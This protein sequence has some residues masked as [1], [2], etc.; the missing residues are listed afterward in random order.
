MR[1]RLYL[2]QVS[3]L[4]A[5]AA[6]LSAQALLQH[7]IAM[8]GGSV[9]G[10]LAGKKL[11]DGLD[12]LL[13]NAAGVTTVSAKT[14]KPSVK[15]KSSSNKSSSSKKAAQTA[16]QTSAK[17]NSE[18]VPGG[19]FVAAEASGPTG[20]SNGRR[21]ASNRTVASILPEEPLTPITQVASLRRNETAYALN[22]WAPAGRTMEAVTVAKLA[23]IKEGATAADLG[24]ELGIPASRVLIPGNDG[25]LLQLVKYKN[26]AG[27]DLG[28]VYLAD[29]KVVNVETTE[30]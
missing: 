2:K 23:A 11:S 6:P 27:K 29:G 28:I 14:G 5:I 10:T 17:T 16:A 7:S 3:V 12:S 1:L 24:T 22:R 8:A 20:K 19:P 13:G 9:A 21:R 25:Q 30:R 4:A 18:L 15:S 26:S